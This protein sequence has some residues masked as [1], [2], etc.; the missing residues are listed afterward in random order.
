MKRALQMGALQ[1]QSSLRERCCSL[2]RR[3]GAYVWQQWCAALLCLRTAPVECDGQLLLA[4]LRGGH[5][6]KYNASP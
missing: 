6:A 2:S 5:H 4:Q 3:V 1:Q